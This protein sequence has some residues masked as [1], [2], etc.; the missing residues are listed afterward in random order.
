[1]QSTNRYIWQTENW[2]QWEAQ[3]SRLAHAYLLTGSAGIGVSDFIADMAKMILCQG[4]ASLSGACGA[5]KQCHLFEQGLHPDF[6]QLDVLEDK[7]DINIDQVRALNK[8]LFET[9]HQGGFKVAVIEQAER[10]NVNAFNALLKTIEEPPAKTLIIL[11]S[12]QE[13]RLPATI[14]SRCRKIRF[15]KPGLETAKAWLA[16]QL[17]QADLSLIKRALKLNWG[18]P[19]NAFKWIEEKQFETE[20]AWQQSLSDLTSG[21]KTI[22]QAVEVWKKF[23]DPMVVFEYFYLWSVNRIRAALYRDK[24]TFDP[25][26]MHFQQMAMQAKQTWRR[27]ANKDLVLEALCMAWLKLQTTEDAQKSTNLSVF[28]P[29]LVRGNL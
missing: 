23:P 7:K 25:Q 27:N 6:F 18:A 28:K 4:E 21:K 1:M 15:A 16:T 3:Q 29:P 19:I 26:W 13:S 22:T 12:Y 5:C 2:Q 9:S 8:K 14:H 11:S 10:L 17:P 24:L 20:A